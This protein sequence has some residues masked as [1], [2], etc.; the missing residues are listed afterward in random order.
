MPAGY[1]IVEHTADI[2]F[3]ASGATPAELFAISAR[4]LMAIAADITNV[5]GTG[6]KRVQVTGHDYESLMVNWLDEILYLFDTSQFV[7]R[8]F[9]ID[10]I[11]PELV[12]A[13]LIGEP[14][15]PDRHPWKLIVK[16]ITY[17]QIE[18]AERNGHWEA[19][20][21]VDV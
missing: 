4:A 13:R 10:E 6:E 16:A 7:A 3:H 8:D 20:V 14:R 21:F 19:T 11:S 5:A 1:Q 18:V 2:G 9:V 17:H 15:D 12:R